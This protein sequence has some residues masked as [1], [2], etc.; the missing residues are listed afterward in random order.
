MPR[1]TAADLTV[2]VIVLDGIVSLR[3]CLAALTTSPEWPRFAILVPSDSRLNGD[4]LKREFPGVRFVGV[5]ERR[6]PAELRAIAVREAHTPLVALTEDHC[7][8]ASSW[9]ATVI[10][11]HSEQSSAAIGGRVEKEIPDGAVGWALYCT[12]YLRYGL[13]DAQRPARELTDCNVSYKRSA[14]AP[15]SRAWDLEFHEPVVHRALA[16]IGETLWFAPQ[17]MVRESRRIRLSQALRDR[18]DFGR[19]FASTRIARRGRLA[20]GA[21]A[22]ASVLLPPL[23]MWRVARQVIGDSRLASGFVRALPVLV[24]TSTAWAAGEMV[25]YATA[26]PGTALT[27]GRR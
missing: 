18:F 24:L 17:M 1:F 14:L 3:K 19:L 11:A 23:L 22:A 13:D 15:V 26:R 20:R 12:D 7:V 9:V 5:A 10:A 8:P 25:G 21:Y 4:E 2:I 16:D 27:P 6:T